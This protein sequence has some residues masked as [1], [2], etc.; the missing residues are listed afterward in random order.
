MPASGEWVRADRIQLLYLQSLPAVAVSL[1]AATLLAALLWPAADH[2]AVLS[3]LAVLVTTSIVRISLFIFYR[4]KAPTGKQLLAWERPYSMTLLLSALTW[5]VGCVWIMPKD[6]LPAQAMALTILIGMA[7]GALS[8]YSA[9]RW[10]TIA[11]IAA[12]LM[13]VTIWLFASGDRTAILLAVGILLFCTSAL[14]AT[15]VLSNTL[16]RNFEMTHELREAKEVAERL[17]STD[18]LTG[19]TNRRAF[20][21]RADAPFHYCRRNG[22]AASAIMLDLDHFKHINDT[23]GHAVGDMALQHAGQLIQS[24]VRKSDLCCRWGGE[25]FVIFLPDTS[26]DEA[27]SVAEKLRIAMAMTAVP[28]PSGDVPITASCGVAEG[29]RDL[30]SLIDRADAALYR[31]KHEGRN[32]VSRDETGDSGWRAPDG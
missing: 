23:R 27:E 17:A 24:T 6:S 4:R 29:H 22:L 20:L 28:V 10:L 32:R 3:W 19:L 25:E 26:L 21:D 1:A 15:K 8:V 30:E 7:G 14:R 13:P 5:G 31:A 18:V 9:L 16:Q 12:I 2:G 11:T